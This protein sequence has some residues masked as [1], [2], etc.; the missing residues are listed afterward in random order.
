MQPGYSTDEILNVEPLRSINE[1]EDS[2]GE[3]FTGSTE[4]LF[5]ML[6]G[7]DDRSQKEKAYAPLH[8]PSLSF[9]KFPFTL[10]FYPFLRKH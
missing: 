9:M 6:M 7:S 8:M 2:N 5:K 10:S 1:L 4:D 3:L